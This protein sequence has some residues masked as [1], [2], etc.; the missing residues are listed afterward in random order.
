MLRAYDFGTFYDHYTYGIRRGEADPLYYATAHA[1]IDY[2]RGTEFIHRISSDSLRGRFWYEFR[3][4]HQAA[5]LSYADHQ[6]IT[7][8]R[9]KR[10]EFAVLAKEKVKV[11]Y[12]YFAV[13]ILTAYI[14]FRTDRSYRRHA[15]PFS[16][17]YPSS[18][19]PRPDPW[20]HRP[21]FCA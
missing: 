15:L 13:K 6:L 2:A 12:F 14:L 18:D 11:P 9:S 3:H 8:V 10:Q 16:H 4:A 20:L 1:L 21:A 7:V 19:H 5:R 17:L